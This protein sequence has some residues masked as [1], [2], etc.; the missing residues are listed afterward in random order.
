MS[1]EHVGCVVVCVVFLEPSVFWCFP[2]TLLFLTSRRHNTGM[3]MIFNYLRLMPSEQFILLSF[4]YFQQKEIDII[5]KL[6]G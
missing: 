6:I 1:P 2:S 5:S 4:A 3:E